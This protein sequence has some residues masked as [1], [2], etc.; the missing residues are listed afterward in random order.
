MPYQDH[1]VLQ[2]WLSLTADELL[3]TDCDGAILMASH[4][5]Q[6]RLPLCKPHDARHLSDIVINSEQHLLAQLITALRRPPDCAI[7]TSLTLSLNKGQLR[8]CNVTVQHLANNASGNGELLWMFKPI[9][10]ARLGPEMIAALVDEC[11]SPLFLIDRQEQ[12]TALNREAERLLG[13]PPPSVARQPPC[14]CA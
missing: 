8:P 13:L 5:M 6:Q 4:A 2:Q 14:R 3:I 11:Q 9:S 12:I 10:W 7:Q 1:N